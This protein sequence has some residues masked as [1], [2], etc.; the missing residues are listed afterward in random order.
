MRLQLRMQMVLKIDEGLIPVHRLI[1]VHRWRR[2]IAASDRFR[3]R[4][5][6]DRL[7]RDNRDRDCSRLGNGQ[8][9][10]ALEG[11]DRHGFQ[12]FD[13]AEFDEYL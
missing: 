10:A 2:T 3:R 9:R 1:A 7:D 5:Q 11:V 4:E 13:P 6:P 12:F 8:H